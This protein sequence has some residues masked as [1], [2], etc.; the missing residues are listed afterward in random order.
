MTDVPG[1]P[2]RRR[3]WPLFGSNGWTITRCTS[4]SRN[5][6]PIWEACLLRRA[7]EAE[8]KGENDVARIRIEEYR[9]IRME[10]V[11]VPVA[12]CEKQIAL[13]REWDRRAKNHLPVAPR[14]IT[15]RNNRR[16][17]AEHGI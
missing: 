13:I 8:A 5:R 9:R 10:F 16:K 15:L 7:N 1:I 2:E 3:A 6:V 17:A 12:D 4:C 11:S 14:I